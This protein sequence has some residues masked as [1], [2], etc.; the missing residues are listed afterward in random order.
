MDR[1]LEASESD[2]ADFPTRVYRWQDGLIEVRQ[3]WLADNHKQFAQMLDYLEAVS[4]RTARAG[5]HALHEWA[6]VLGQR[7]DEHR[8]S[9]WPMRVGPEAVRGA[10]ADVGLR[11]THFDAWRFFTPEATGLNPW[12]LSRV[13]S[14]E[15]NV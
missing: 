4:S 10:I 3:E 5:C 12:P 6:M 2:Y 14:E 8:H 15:H 1:W 7:S 9:T 13:R 11:C